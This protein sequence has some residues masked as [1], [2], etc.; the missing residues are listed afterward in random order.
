MIRT[1]TNGEP[2]GSVATPVMIPVG[3][4]QRAVHGATNQKSESLISKLGMRPPDP[5]PVS[6]E[7]DFPNRLL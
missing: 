2:A 3:A 1:P 4:W 5:K 6:S 7:C